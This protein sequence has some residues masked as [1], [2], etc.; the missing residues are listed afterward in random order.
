M[1]RFCCALLLV[2]AFFSGTARAEGLAVVDAERIFR[3]SLPGKAGETHLTQA[4]DILQ[5]GLD[6][7]RGHYKGKENTAEAI[8]ALREGQAALERQFAAERLAVRK[9]LAATLENVIRVWFAT[10]GKSAAISAVAPASALFAYSPALDVTDAVL[11]EMDKEK[12]VFHAL[13]TVTVTANPATGP[14][15]SP[16]AS[17]GKSGQAAPARA[18]TRTR[19]Q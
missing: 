7:L 1:T 15:A 8:S 6:E 5:K 4:R 3:D 9:V 11:R 17:P 18:P 10:N 16:L 2:L 12:P 13:P 19:S 14:Q